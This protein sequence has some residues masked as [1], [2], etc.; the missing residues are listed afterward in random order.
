MIELTE[1]QELTKY[2]ETHPTVVALFYSSWCPF[3]R[4]FLP[5]FDKHAQKAGSDIF[6]KVMI[7]DDENPIWETYSLEA[8]PSIILF[9]KGKV[10]QR[11]DCQL[12][13][14]LNEKQL[15]NFLDKI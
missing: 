14:G 6:I 11:L 15:I 12:G 9:E 2:I 8:V 10:K 7:D 13:A 3:C 4:S 5:T 1:E